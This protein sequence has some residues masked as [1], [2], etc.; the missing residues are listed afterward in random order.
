MKFE[1]NWANGLWENYVLIYWLDLN[2]SALGWKAKGQPW[3]LK[4]IYSHCLIRF[5]ISSK[6]NDFG[7][8]SI[9]KI[10][11]SKKNPI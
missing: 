6:N 10:N 8:N 5:N 11:F 3:P 2:M 7:F 4:L 9:Q 1:L